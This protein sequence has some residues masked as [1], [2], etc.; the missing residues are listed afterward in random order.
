MQ[1][2]GLWK[3]VLAFLLGL[4]LGLSLDTVPAPG[5]VVVFDDARPASERWAA[6]EPL[7]AERDAARLAEPQ[8]VVV[9]PHSEDD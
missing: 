9:G 1:G 7:A 2:L 6:D 3:G 8:T 4:V 5:E